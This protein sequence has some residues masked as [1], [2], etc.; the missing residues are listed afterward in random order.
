MA[1]LVRG[2]FEYF[3]GAEKDK[4]IYEYVD[5]LLVLFP[6]F[7]H[8]TLSKLIIES[9]DET[10]R[11]EVY[12]IISDVRIAME[13]LGFIEFAPN[14]NIAYVLTDKG[15][16]AKKKGGYFKYQKSL[17]PK[18]DWYKIIPIILT[19][20]FGSSTLILSIKRDKTV[21]E[22]AFL[23]KENDSLKSVININKNK[24]QKFSK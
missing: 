15:R 19:I 10:E 8:C 20:I 14:S 5:R 2:N 16:L 17:E 13:K 18:T 3:N 23:K 1:A 12:S 9:F 4:K 24:Q 7:N 11:S 21:S 6:D 22:N